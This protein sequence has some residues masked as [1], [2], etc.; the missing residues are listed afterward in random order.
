MFEDTAD[1]RRVAPLRKLPDDCL[2]EG[3]GLRL[4]FVIRMLRFSASQKKGVPRSFL[5]SINIINISINSIF[6]KN[7]LIPYTPFFSPVEME[8]SACIIV[9]YSE[10]HRENT[11][12]C[13]P[14]AVAECDARTY[15]NIPF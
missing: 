14:T 10:S 15:S 3:V 6:I 13:L 12:A 7:N 8:G 11:R 2:V 4:A 5:I 1:W 9:Y